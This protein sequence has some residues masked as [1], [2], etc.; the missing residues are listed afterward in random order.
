VTITETMR[1]PH[2][3]HTSSATGS[4]MRESR[5]PWTDEN[6]RGLEHAEHADWSAAA[7]AFAS[8]ADTLGAKDSPEAASHEALALVLGN[9]ANACFRAGRVDD[10][11]RHAQRACA[12]RVAL[13]GEDAITVA[14][15]RCDLAIMLCSVDRADEAAALLKRAIAGIEQYAGDEDAR[16]IPVLENAARVAMVMSEPASAEPYL[17]RMHSL[18][19]VHNLPVDRAESLL[20]RVAQARAGA[21]RAFDLEPVP[22]LHSDADDQPLRDAVVVTEGLLRTT[23]TGSPI[24][25]RA[26]VLDDGWSSAHHA[27]TPNGALEVLRFGTQTPMTEPLA[28]DADVVETFALELERDLQAT[29][30]SSPLGFAVEYGFSG[31]E[32]Q[33]VPKLDTTISG[34]L[35]LVDLPVPVLLTDAPEP[36]IEIF[37][38]VFVTTAATPLEVQPGAEVAAFLRP[39]TRRSSPRSIAV[40]MPSPSAG[41]PAHGGSDASDLDEGDDDSEPKNT[42]M[43]REELPREHRPFGAA[44]RAGRA[45]APQS[46]RGMVLAAIATLG[47][48]GAAA[49]VYLHGG[50]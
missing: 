13:V 1:H 42:L 34:D 49:W 5:L 24:I 39:P 11:I 26:E 19:A 37:E 50:F 48:G 28:D 45:T 16:L 8:A 25:R 21:P 36:V 30:P 47:L 46:S 32:D 33:S 15:A 4:D 10:G 3:M 35:E 44:L 12:L 17:L 40:V 41:V 27:I 9:L 31:Y 14:R 22:E 23:P 29:L 43:V 2:A 18:L 7:E 38:P 20:A 6:S